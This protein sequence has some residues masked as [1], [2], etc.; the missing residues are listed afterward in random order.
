MAVFRVHTPRLRT[1]LRV[2]LLRR[3][4]VSGF[5]ACAR[6]RGRRRESLPGAFLVGLGGASA[7]QIPVAVD[8]A[9]KCDCQRASPHVNKQV[10]LTC[11]EEARGSLLMQNA[12]YSM[13]AFFVNVHIPATRAGKGE[14]CFIDALQINAAIQSGVTSI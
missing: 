7:P 6:R 5:V 11:P 2:W 3:K 8:D 14:Q 12:N 10:T 13:R 1:K 4:R 9:L